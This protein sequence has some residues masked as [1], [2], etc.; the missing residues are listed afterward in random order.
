M[1]AAINGLAFLTINESDFGMACNIIDTS[2]D[3]RQIPLSQGKFAIVDADDYEW[4]IQW[5]LASLPL[6]SIGGNRD[7][8][9]RL[10]RWNRI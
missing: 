4:L 1:P 8:S 9:L 3:Y 2:Q 7:E 5:K 10:Y 6:Q